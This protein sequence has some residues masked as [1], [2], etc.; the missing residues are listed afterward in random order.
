MLCW[1]LW[2]VIAVVSA[3]HSHT[4]NKRK[5]SL[6]LEDS[7]A[8]KLDMTEVEVAKR[9]RS[10]V[11]GKFIQAA[12]NLDQAINTGAPTKTIEN[13]YGELKAA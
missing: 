6:Q 9:L 1:N 7:G 8:K 2:I 4:T 12:N 3:K 10:T 13:S 11:K 5:L